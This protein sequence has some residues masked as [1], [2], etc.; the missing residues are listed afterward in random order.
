MDVASS[1]IALTATYA[2]LFALER[3]FPLRR[4]TAPLLRR[5]WVNLAISV[6]AFATAAALVRPGAVAALDFTTTR[7]L[8]LIK[9]AGLEG[10]AEW[11]ASFVLLDLTFYYW[12]RANHGWWFLWRFHNVHH[13]DPDLDVTTGFR[14]HF[15]EVALS[16]A[17]RIVQLIAIGPSLAAFAIY[18][19][20]FQSFTLFHHSNLRL[21][22]RVEAALNRVVVTPRMHGIHHSD[23]RDETNSNFGV[24]FRWWDALHGTLRLDV[25]QADIDIGIPAYSAPGDNRLLACV[26]LPLVP[27]RDYWRSANGFRLTRNGSATDRQRRKLAP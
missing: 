10:P 20:A 26:V 24:V 7:S 9:L 13:I 25:P 21:P 4:S 14:F 1:V 15:V 19:V 6:A 27:Q 12:H 18:E 16:A 23:F 11:I 8:G 17:F 5:V 22:Y 2:V 3:A